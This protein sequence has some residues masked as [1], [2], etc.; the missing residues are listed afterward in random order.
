MIPCNNMLMVTV[1]SISRC[2]HVTTCLQSGLAQSGF[3]GMDFLTS[4]RCPVDSGLSHVSSSKKPF[5]VL[6]AVAAMPFVTCKTRSNS[7]GSEVPKTPAWTLSRVDWKS[8]DPGEEGLDTTDL[9]SFE[10]TSL[11]F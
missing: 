3:A 4:L 1:Y 10:T 7:N 11:T 9:E 2:Y 6:L 5:P 8:G